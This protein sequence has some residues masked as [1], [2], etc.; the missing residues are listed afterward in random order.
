MGFGSNGSKQVGPT[1]CKLKADGAFKGTQNQVGSYYL[2]LRSFVVIS[3]DTLFE[4]PSAL[5]CC[6]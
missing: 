5:D 1:R 2:H 3:I 6:W 4:E